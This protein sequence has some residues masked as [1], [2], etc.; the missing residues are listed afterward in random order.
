MSYWAIQQDNPSATVEDLGPQVDNAMQQRSEVSG[1]V[2]ADPGM[3][4]GRICGGWPDQ[5]SR[6]CLWL[7]DALIASAH[8]T[9]FQHGNHAHSVIDHW[10]QFQMG[11]KEEAD[12]ILRPS[13]RDENQAAQQAVIHHHPDAKLQ[14]KHSSAGA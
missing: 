14:T 9:A 10:Q 13:I 1:L 8:G 6:C 4:E 3:T 12:W 11:A 2:E 5:A 7:D